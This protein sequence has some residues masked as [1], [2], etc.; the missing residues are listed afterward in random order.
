MLGLLLILTDYQQYLNSVSATPL[1]IGV[2]VLMGL[3]LYS[4]VFWDVT[5]CNLVNVC[6][7]TGTTVLLAYFLLRLLFYPEDGGNMFC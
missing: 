7:R 6:F 3:I 4:D 2:E 5:P 1:C